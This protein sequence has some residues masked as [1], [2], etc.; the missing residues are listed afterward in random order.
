MAAISPTE[1]DERLQSEDP[2]RVPDI[3]HADA[4]EDWHIPG[5]ENIPVYDA[6]K[7][8]SD[9]A[10]DA[11]ADLPKDEEIVTVCAVGG[12]SQTATEDL[13]DLGYEAATLVDGMAGW[14]RVHRHAAVDVDLD[15]TLDQ[16]ARPGKGCL[17]H[18]LV[19]EG[20][21]VVFDPSQYAEEY[22]ALLDEYGAD[23]VG[24]FDT[25]A[26]ADHVSRGRRLA[27]DHG[28][29]Y[30]LHP[31]DAIDYH[32]AETRRPVWCGE[33]SASIRPALPVW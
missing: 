25:H 23:L 26:H 28:V 13:Q 31:A 22:D 14:S 29:P 24:V 8:G 20:D 17:S 9:E 21:A 12:V 6:L 27:E 15:G 7:N 10:R 30:H 11:F 4:L 5:S 3:R 18:V 2:P 16:V 1:L 19:S 33:P 32:C